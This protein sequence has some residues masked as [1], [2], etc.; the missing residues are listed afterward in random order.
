MLIRI[1]QSI[2]KHINYNST[3]HTTLLPNNKWINDNKFPLWRHNLKV[4]KNKSC[5][6]FTNHFSGDMCIC[7]QSVQFSSV[8][9]SCPT[10]WPHGLKHL[11]ITNSWS[12][13]KF[14]SIEFVMPSNHLILGHPLLLPPSL[15]PSIRV[16]SSE[17]VLCIKWPK[18]WSFS[19][20]I[21][22]SNEYSGLIYFRIDSLDLL[23]TQG[24]FKSLHQHHSSKTS[25]LWHSAFF[26]PKC[27]DT[28]AS[29]FL[30]PVYSPILVIIFSLFQ[31]S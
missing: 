8:A 26:I 9:Q 10:L 16:F 14:M 11:V 13:L 22:P 28:K 25:I 3:L 23:T 17:S 1:I 18:Y 15:F 2:L 6:C 20:S 27:K 24:T 7:H 31:A 21:S 29:S 4:S 19:F 5:T 30:N 12:L